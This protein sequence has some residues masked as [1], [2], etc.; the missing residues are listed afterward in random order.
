[1]PWIWILLALGGVTS[2]FLH[3]T[4][5]QES[6][7]ANGWDGY[8]YLVQ[9]KSLV[10]TGEMHSRDYSPVYLLLRGFY[11]IC[12]DYVLAYK[13]LSA[14]LAA[15]FTFLVGWIAQ[16]FS[17][18]IWVVLILVLW[19]LS[20]SSLGFFM[21]NFP[22]NLLG[23]NFLLLCMGF[24][25]QPGQW[26]RFLGLGG[27]LW[28][29]RM[30]AGLGLLFLLGEQL[31]WKRLGYAFAAGLGLVLV[32]LAV[33]GL[34]NLSDFQRFEGAFD[35]PGW[36]HLRF[37]NLLGRE[38][39]PMTWKTELLLGSLG[40]LLLGLAWVRRPF[41]FNQQLK[42]MRGLTFLALVLF[43][44]FFKM[45]L[46]GIGY[47]FFLAGMLLSPLFFLPYL[48]QIKKVFFWG[49]LGLLIFANG[50]RF[51]TF[52]LKAFDPD[53]GYFQMI[54][55]QIPA[56]EVPIELIIGHKSMA[57]LIT[58]E[59]GI[60]VLPWQPE[61]EVDSL[62]LWRISAD[63]FASDFRAY[64]S[65]E[66]WKTVYRISADY[67]FLREDLWQRFR[68]RV[69]RN[70]DEELLERIVSWRNPYRMRPAFVGNKEN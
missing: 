47:R 59:R 68:G 5:L 69:E 54:G 19:S 46:T 38:N 21:A 52:S 8:F 67:H 30:T 50:L 58:F 66:E 45:D 32:A 13:L 44:P 28:S 63:I 14:G 12:G 49:L 4:L 7:F 29:H 24:S 55:G 64:L 56:D 34:L 39:I 60:D 43:C 23:L 53:Y 37:A 62:K 27:A 6:P 16:R 26:P 57:E 2:F 15:S 65:A 40:L 31:T 51:Q 41:A 1:M 48:S 36:P 25:L 42:W 20:S 11:A 10:E 18:N 3:L 17:Q 35:W 22:K 70:G 9:L 61:Y 33:P